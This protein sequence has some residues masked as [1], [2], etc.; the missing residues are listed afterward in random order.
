[1]TKKLLGGAGARS[2]GAGV[3]GDAVS[4]RTV[5]K[6]KLG[7]DVACCPAV[8]SLWGGGFLN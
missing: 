2:G 7:S 4:I 8:S 6:H 3:G 5:P 1:M